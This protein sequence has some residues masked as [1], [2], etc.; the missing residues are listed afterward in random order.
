M[1]CRKP[2]IREA[3]NEDSPRIQE[4][5]KGN[6]L[7]VDGL[8]WSYLEGWYVGLHK[9]EVVGATQILPGKPCG[10]IM[11][12]TVDSEYIGSGLGYV[13]W[14]FAKAMLGV[15]GCD[16]ILAFTDN[17]WILRKEKKLGI[18]VLKPFTATCQRIVNL[19][20]LQHESAYLQ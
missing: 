7:W 6:G 10:C 11:Y 18:T 20:K 1:I 15:R 14:Q 8:D 13:L 5:L 17:E 4:M 9:G 19:R 16:A 2:I 3:T 12:I